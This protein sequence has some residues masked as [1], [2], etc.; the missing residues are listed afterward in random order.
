[1]LM[2]LKIKSGDFSSKYSLTLTDG[3][4]LFVEKGFWGE[5]R[6]I[7]LAFSEID[8]VL[9]NTPKTAFF[10]VS[11]TPPVL[12]VYSSRPERFS[13]PFNRKKR[14]HQQVIDAM[15]AGLRKSEQPG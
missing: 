5:K 4:L 14:A 10:Q 9:L 12:T 6:R 8:C 11:A 3:G 7:N 2:A 15:L 1:M 13:I